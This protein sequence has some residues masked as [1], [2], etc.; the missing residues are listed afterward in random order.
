MPLVH[1]REPFDHPDWLFELKYDGFRAIAYIDGGGTKLVSRR[2]LEY[3]RFEDLRSE[4]SLEINADDAVLDGEIVK[5]DGEG[6]P[7]FVDLM[8][9]ADPSRSSRA[10]SWPRTARTFESSRS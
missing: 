1:A 2:D 6:R 4:L 8:R 9:G 5:L 10:T 3:R 7:S